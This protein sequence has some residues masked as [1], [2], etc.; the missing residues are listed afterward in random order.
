MLRPRILFTLS[1]GLFLSHILVARKC[2]PPFLP[3]P[4]STN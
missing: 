2:I 1:L 3:L 4:P